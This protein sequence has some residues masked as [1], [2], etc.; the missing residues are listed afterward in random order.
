MIPKS[1]LLLHPSL[2]ASKKQK[3]HFSGKENHFSI[4]HVWKLLT[5]LL[6]LKKISGKLFID[7]DENLPPT[8]T[9]NI[10]IKCYE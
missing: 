5:I 9:S 6:P 10:K 7:Y 8:I 3:E 2:I 4:I 1:R